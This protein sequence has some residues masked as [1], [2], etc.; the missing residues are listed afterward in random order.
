M[1]LTKKHFTQSSKI[2]KDLAVVQLSDLHYTETMDPNK[3]KTIVRRVYDLNPNY[4]IFCGDIFYE[5]SDNFDNLFLFFQALGK[6]APVYITFGDHDYMMKN[7]DLNDIEKGLWVPRFEDEAVNEIKNITNIKVLDNDRV[8][9]KDYNVMLVGINMDF[10]HYEKEKENSDDFSGINNYRFY[11]ALP[12]ETFNEISCHSPINI[13]R[14]NAAK[15]L[16]IVRNAD[17][18]H[19]GHMHNGM[20]PNFLDSLVPKNIGMFDSRGNILP[21][22]A[23]KEVKRDNTLGI[24]GGPLTSKPELKGKKLRLSEE[25]WPSTIDVV[26]VKK[27]TK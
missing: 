17:L 18:I 12:Q 27:M 23:R 16:K 19:T 8:Y 13:L 5:K 14:K 15:K 2:S 24:I 26:Y 4:I 25:I 7:Q 20:I 21:L 3:L 1:I 9:L 11:T 6:I 10:H 22:L